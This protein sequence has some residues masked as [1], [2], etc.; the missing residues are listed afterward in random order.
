MSIWRVLSLFTISILF[1]LLDWHQKRKSRR[2]EKTRPREKN[3]PPKIFEKTMGS[4]KSKQKPQELEQPPPPGPRD[5]SYAQQPQKRKFM[6][7]LISYS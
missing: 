2:T 3:S 6:F 4:K 5:D 1:E 7:F